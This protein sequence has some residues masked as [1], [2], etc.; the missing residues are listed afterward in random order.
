M[1]TIPDKTGL[2]FGR[3]VVQRRAGSVGRRAAWLCLCDCGTERVL[4]SQILSEGAS[5]SCGCLQ[6]ER[7]SA[8]AKTHGESRSRLYKQ[9]TSMKQ[10]CGNP[11]DRQ[12][13][14]YGGR[15]ITVCAEWMASFEAFSAHVG[16][17]P[18]GTSL[19]RIDNS[20]GY[21]PGNVRWATGS[22]QLANTRRA[23][24]LTYRGETMC[25]RHWSARLGIAY[26]TLFQR[27]IHRGWT[28]ERAFETPVNK[29]L[30]RR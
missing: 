22:E 3:W 29:A 13:A 17:K 25:M 26:M 23:I 8:A 18:V 16:H 5:L 7:V 14:L 6:K 9:W 21:E 15:G 24:Q 30:A 1:P 12:Y 4:N 28:A 10:R 11:K 2:R 27:I 19:D 20:K